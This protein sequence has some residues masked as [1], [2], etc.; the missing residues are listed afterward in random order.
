MQNQLDFLTELYR[1]N[2]WA[3]RKT[4]AAASSLDPENFT[5][6][7]G[8]SFS[9][10][11]DTLVHILGAEWIWLERWNGRFPRSL[12]AAPEF[13][14]VAAIT[15]RW[16]Q[17]EDGQTTFLHSRTPSDLNKNLSYVNQKGETWSYPLVQQMVHVVNHSTYHRGQV[18]TLLRQLGA[19]PATTDFLNYYDEQGQR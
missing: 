11:R 19:Q 6:A 12:L 9:S 1:Y 18:T 16:K 8:N 5:R 13:S 14:D 15:Q 10:V 3:N 17:V 2:R 4:L 7:L